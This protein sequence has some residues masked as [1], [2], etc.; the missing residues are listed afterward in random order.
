MSLLSSAVAI[1]NSVTLSLGLQATVTHES[2]LGQT[3]KGDRS[4]SAPVVRDAIVTMKNRTAMSPSGEMTV[5]HAQ[6]VILDPSVAITDEDRFTLP[7]GTTA[8]ILDRRGFI[9]RSTG[10]PI[11]QEV[12]LARVGA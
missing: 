5:S 6:I 2:Y 7:D 1:A 10:L 12:F 9:D 4:Y 3:A 11:L 8:P